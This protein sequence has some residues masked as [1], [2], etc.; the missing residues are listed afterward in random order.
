MLGNRDAAARHWRAAA[1]TARTLDT[2]FSVPAVLAECAQAARS[3]GRLADAAVM[4]AVADELSPQQDER[5]RTHLAGVA[6]ALA[7]DIG[8][9]VS[10]HW[11]KGVASSEPA[12]DSDQLGEGFRDLVRRADTVSGRH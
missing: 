11:W 10:A 8:D 4:L 7:A 2:E 3:E 12:P 9:V 6:A 5:L 1:D